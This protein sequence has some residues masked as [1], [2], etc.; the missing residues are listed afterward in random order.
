MKDIF[1]DVEP[2]ED[3]RTEDILEVPLDMPADA[4]EQEGPFV[5]D[6]DSVNMVLEF[7]RHKRGNEALKEL[8]EQ[9]LND[10]DS[11]WDASEEYR[12][13][14]AQSYR[15]FTGD[16]PPKNFP[17][18]DCANAHIPILLENG[19]RLVFRIASELFGDWSST[20]GFTP[21]GPDDEATADVLTKHGNWQIRNKIV[22][23]RRQMMRALTFYI[24]NGDVTGLS[25]Y[26]AMERRNRHDILT[27]DEF[28]LPFS[29]ASATPDY[30]DVPYKMQVLRY[31]RHE[32]QR[33]RGLWENVDAVLAR[34]APDWDTDPE[35]TL[36]E[37]HAEVTRVQQET[38][39]RYTP[40]KLI[41]YEGWTDL[42]PDQLNDRYV[43][44]IV[45]TTTRQV[46][47][48][49]I[50]EEEDWQERERYN[51][52]MAEL[53]SYREQ[54][55][56]YGQA[57]TALEETEARHEGTIGAETASD[58]EKAVAMADLKGLRAA[59]I[60]PPPIPPQ[61]MVDPA[62]PLEVPKPPQRKPINMYSHG[63]CIE[64]LTGVVG[65]GYG[66]I[67][68]DLNVA[69]N[70][71]VSQ[72]TDAATLAN[73]WGMLVSEEFDPTNELEVSPG[74]FTKVKGLSSAELKNAVMELRPSP[75][76]PQLME[77]VRLMREMASDAA[78]APDVLS[79][80][81]GKS[82]ETYRG[83]SARIE[84]ATL[85]LGV[86]ARNFANFFEQ[87]LKNNAKLNSIYL[88][89]EEII[90]ISAQP[91]MASEPVVIRRDMY[92]KNYQIEVRSDLKFTSM[93]QRIAEADEVLG[94]VMSNL[95][96][97]MNMGLVYETVKQCLI[98]RDMHN[99]VPL[100]GPP[101]P[102]LTVP[103]SPPGMPPAPPGAPAPAGPPA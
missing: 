11:A 4:A 29:M 16:L 71:A 34:K 81:A 15:L 87:I 95:I 55:D 37:T 93:A 17:F 46:L 91:G 38:D 67:L 7:S 60:P 44:I 100:L 52:E 68:T 63:V 58:Y 3:F 102:P 85:Q 54:N 83:H 72:F 10:F 69:A 47:H 84:Q 23:F 82:G 65:I 99:L 59:P 74:K 49:S 36:R 78:Q 56:A 43:K 41:Q 33:M 45:D 92:K 18:K 97:M 2:P 79:G 30:S 21:I 25:R 53:V 61:W 24:I 73:C 42:L 9:V 14:A 48:L 51:Q 35:A 31:Y 75:A 96:L 70:V 26:D 101:P 22:D 57:I 20:Y 89:D 27:V 94:I 12:E 13:R 40:Y 98:A 66:R 103:M 19:S 5:Y 39:P 77:L 6:E 80:A 8:A 64:P 32:L 86:V 76:N 1:M 90:N 50:H 62:D 88:P 28:V